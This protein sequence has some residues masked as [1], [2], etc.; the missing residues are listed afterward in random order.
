MLSIN[1]MLVI[2][3]QMHAS[4]LHLSGGVP[5]KV[6]VFGDLVDIEGCSILTPAD[7][8]ELGYSIIPPQ[9]VQRFEVI[10]PRIS[11]LL[12]HLLIHPYLEQ[13]DA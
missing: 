12:Y 1:E 4:D 6:R 9:L 3:N 7:T 8:A 13:L 10:P 2:A 11:Q 5:P